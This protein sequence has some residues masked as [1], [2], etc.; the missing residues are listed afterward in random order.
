MRQVRAAVLREQNENEEEDEE[1]EE[2]REMM[3]ERGANSRGSSD[4]S[5]SL[6]DDQSFTGCDC[7]LTHTHKLNCL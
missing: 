3:R 7:P 6:S 4:R 2:E 1:E 5:V